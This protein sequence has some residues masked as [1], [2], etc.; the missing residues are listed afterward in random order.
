[1]RLDQ[2]E[3]PERREQSKAVATADEQH[4]GLLDGIA[5]ILDG[6]QA[7]DR[8][9]ERIEGGLGPRGVGVVVGDGER[10]EEDSWRVA[11]D[12]TQ[13]WEGVLERRVAV[14][15]GATQ[16]EEIGNHRRHL[17]EGRAEQRRPARSDD[18]LVP[19][20]YDS[21]AARPLNGASS[22]S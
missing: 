22:R 11:D 13:G 1:D 10:R 16:Q 19:S 5:R 12:L 18:T 21:G 2:A 8:H 17:L 3:L 6:V 9:P 15:A 20:S 7:D 4:L 14:H